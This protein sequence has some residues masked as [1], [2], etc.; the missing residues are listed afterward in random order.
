MRTPGGARNCKPES[1]RLLAATSRQVQAPF[2]NVSPRLSSHAAIPMTKSLAARRFRFVKREVPGNIDNLA[3]LL[4]VT[5]SVIVRAVR[6]RVT[7]DEARAEEA[8]S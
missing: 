5:V 7:R 3:A 8:G 6:R 4:G 1:W 2:A